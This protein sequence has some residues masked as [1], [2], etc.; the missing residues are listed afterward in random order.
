MTALSE[1]IWYE[2]KTSVEKKKKEKREEEEEEEFNHNCQQYKRNSIDKERRR[3]KTIQ[4]VQDG[5]HKIRVCVSFDLLETSPIED[6]H[7]LMD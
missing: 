4:A 6:V 5:I 1:Q 2:M 3:I 7:F